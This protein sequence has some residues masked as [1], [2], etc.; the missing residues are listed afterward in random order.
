VELLM[1]LPLTQASS[2]AAYLRRNL[3]KLKDKPTW[4]V[5]L[6]MYGVH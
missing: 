2:H 4:F 6:I 3:V 5:S 1:V